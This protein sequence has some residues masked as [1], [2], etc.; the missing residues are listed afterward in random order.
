MD[1]KALT[2]FIAVYEKNSISAAAKACFVAQP[3][4]SAAIKQLE[5]S[6]DNQLFTRHARG[7]EATEAG[8]RLYPMAKQLLGQA[9]AIESAFTEQTRAVPFRLGLIGALGVERMS[10]LLKEFTSAIES[11]EL[12]LVGHDEECDARI[13]SEPYLQPTE[14]FVPMWEDRF[15]LAMPT[16]HRLQFR[17]HVALEEFRDLPMIQRTPCE[18]WNT[19]TEALNQ[20]DI[21][22]VI[23]AKIHTLEYALGMVRSG[24]GCAL[25]PTVPQIMQAQDVLFKSVDGIKLGRTI[26]L[27]YQSESEPVNIL[28]QLAAKRR[29]GAKP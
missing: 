11:L 13:I 16:H 27:A 2:Y 5:Q 25:L 24:V 20:T 18:G 22:L 17:Q 21:E 28:K 19:L 9:A 10:L 15:M 26:G 8:T 29:P 23:R 1:L 6:L 3:S 4:I 12:T 7:V 14:Q